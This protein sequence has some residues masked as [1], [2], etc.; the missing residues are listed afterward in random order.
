MS[1]IPDFLSVCTS[2]ICIIKNERQI[3]FISGPFHAYAPLCHHNLLIPVPPIL[4]EDP[5]FPFGESLTPSVAMHKKHVNELCSWAYPGSESLPSRDSIAV[6]STT[7]NAIL[8]NLKSYAVSVQ[9]VN[10]LSL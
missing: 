1:H 5:S 9:S 4:R 3:S 10:A 6:T 7:A 2:T 8:S